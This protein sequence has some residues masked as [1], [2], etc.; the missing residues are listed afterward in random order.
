MIIQSSGRIS[1]VQEVLIMREVSELILGVHLDREFTLNFESPK[2]DRV[3]LFRHG[4]RV[5]DH[6]MLFPPKSKGASP[7]AQAD[8]DD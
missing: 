7:K 1:K 4:E 5:F 2:S 3:A 6:V 8:C